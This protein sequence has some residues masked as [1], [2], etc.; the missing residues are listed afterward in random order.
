[1]SV[2]LQEADGTTVLFTKG[3]DSEIFKRLRAGDDDVKATV[4]DDLKY[5][6]KLGYRTLALGVR[7]FAPGEID[8][9]LKSYKEVRAPCHA[10][11]PAADDHRR[12]PRSRIATAC[13]AKSMSS[14]S[15]TLTS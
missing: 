4:S 10:A 5:Y 15:T 14:S 13:W 11:S 9:W 1:M 7:T 12:A 6:S 3:A 2:L 8:A